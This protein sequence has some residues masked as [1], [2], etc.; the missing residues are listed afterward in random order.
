MAK[1]T[2][3]ERSK[4][5]ER[6]L[7]GLMGQRGVT[8]AAVVD[9]DGFVTNIRHDFDIDVDALGAAIQI[10]NGSTQRAAANVKQGGANLVLSENREGLVLMAPF[11]RDDDF[12]LALVADKSAM[13]G[14]V[15]YEV[16]ETVGDLNRLFT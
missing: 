8:A 11:G 15:R 5:V 2:R 3:A 16:K 14:A 4:E 1:M 7:M 12:I 10:V 9:S 6:L 13:L